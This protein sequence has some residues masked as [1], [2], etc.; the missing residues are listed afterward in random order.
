MRAF[1]CITVLAALLVFP[2]GTDP[3]EALVAPDGGDET[4]GSRDAIDR[5]LDWLL[6]A[7]NKDGSWGLDKGTRGD[8]SCTGLAALAL[9]AAGTTE[10]NGPSPSRVRALRKATEYIMGKARRMRGDIVR[11]ETTLIQRKLGR[12]IHNFFAT[13][14]LTQAYGMRGGWMADEQLEEMRDI[15]GRLADVIASSQEKDGSW[16]KDTFGSLKATCMAWLALRSANSVGVDVSQAAVDRTVAFIKKQYNPSSR[17]FDKFARQGSYQTIYASASCLRVLYAMG[18][19]KS[20]EAQGSAKAL[21][22]MLKTGFQQFLSVEGEDYLAAAMISQ[23]LRFER[24]QLW[25]DWF[26]WIRKRLMD[27]QAK[28]GTWTST[29]CITGRTFPTSCALLALQAP[30]HLLPIAEE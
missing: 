5:G 23:A 9:M 22:K 1:V 6:R 3:Y 13:V 17:L 20:Q 7:Q 10:R 25:Q 30:R 16:H 26:P 19:G 12:K 28:D 8:I 24:G 4:N 11:G 14:Q 29:A 15:L 21:V 2:A 18:E 27:K